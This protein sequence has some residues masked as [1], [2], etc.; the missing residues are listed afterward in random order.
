M[1]VLIALFA[2]NIMLMPEL[3][4][5]ARR[6]LGHDG[7]ELSCLLLADRDVDLD[8]AAKAGIGQVYHVAIGQG[9]HRGEVLLSALESLAKEHAPQLILM[10]HNEKTAELGPRLAARMR[11]PLIT[12]AVNVER[13]ENDDC[14]WIR[15]VYGG[16][17]LAKLRYTGSTVIVTVRKNSFE[18]V[19]NLEVTV[20]RIPFEVQAPEVR[21]QL[22]EYSLDSG[23]GNRLEES[24]VVVSGGRGLGGPAGFD[25]LRELAV[26]FGGAVG[27]SRAAVDAGWVPVSYQVGQTGKMISP[28][29]YFAVGISGA[30]QHL[31]G[32]AN[33]KHVIAINKDPEA[34]IFKRAELGIVGDYREVLPILKEKL[35]SVLNRQG[36]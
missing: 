19:D 34:P 31:A 14:L 11:C 8:V 13:T 23:D 28:D 30:S 7:G 17:A 27:A 9:D 35:S 3:S 6:A 4:G 15:P 26:M 24:R 21:I 5:A 16:K 36:V 10:P 32:I 12:D 29:I 1:R 2:E 22:I 25:L 18:P 33:A 20:E